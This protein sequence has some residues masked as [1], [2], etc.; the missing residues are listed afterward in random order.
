M[1]FRVAKR[2]RGQSW[3][4]DWRDGGIRYRPSLGRVSRDAAERLRVQK[5]AELQGIIAPAGSVLVEDV[6][7]EYLAWYERARPASYAQAHS[8]IKPF[9]ATFGSVP[10]SMVSPREVEAW[11]LA[12]KHRGASNHAVKIAKTAFRY[13]VRIG[14]IRINPMEAVRPSAP[15]VSRAP[16]YFKPDELR[17][18]YG[19]A[20][21]PLWRFMANTGVRRGEMFKARRDD[22]RD[23][24]LYVES[25]S[26]GRT[27][28]GKWRAIPL[29]AEARAAL[30]GLGN[31]RLVTC[32]SVWTLSDWFRR[33]AD[34]VGIR[35]TLHWLRHT[36]CTGL[37]QA[38]VSLH[39]VQLLA[40]HSTVV[41][42]E[43]YA[44][45]APGRGV[46]AVDALAKWS[47][48][49]AQNGHNGKRKSTRRIRAVSRTA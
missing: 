42:T 28:S 46:A 38:G 24:S 34:S 9:T 7:S 25:V 22:V 2:K 48:K 26:G 5:E 4:L 37:V 39:D 32:A 30:N 33:E 43:R 35:G 17:D 31:D 13:A 1:A 45:H 19:C 6:I 8:A 44:H 12:A 14:L 23:G 41:V 3:Y 10:A 29:N 21:G 36:F 15:P 11:E 49:M 16:A 40:G 20:H 27:K 47:Q 18:L